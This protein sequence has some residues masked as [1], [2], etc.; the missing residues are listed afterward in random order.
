MDSAWCAKSRPPAR[1]LP[2]DPGPAAR[3]LQQDMPLR[4]ARP[5]TKG[6]TPK[7]RHQLHIAARDDLNLVAPAAMQ[8]NGGQGG[9]RS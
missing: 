4:P 2:V 6:A 5:P 3:H 7:M 1:T 8:C 9:F